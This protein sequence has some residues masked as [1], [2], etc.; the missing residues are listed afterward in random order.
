MLLVD[1]ESFEMNLF[2]NRA[3]IM[4]SK[5]K[6]LQEINYTRNVKKKANLRLLFMCPEQSFR[7]GADRLLVLFR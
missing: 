7:Q 2:N 6:E 4:L 1:L 5:N 3:E